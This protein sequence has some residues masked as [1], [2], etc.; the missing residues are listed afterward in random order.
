MFASGVGR[1][2][3]DELKANRLHQTAHGQNVRIPIKPFVVSDIPV[4]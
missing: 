1:K 2:P 4:I 3:T